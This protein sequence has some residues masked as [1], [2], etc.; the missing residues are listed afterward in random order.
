MALD[1]I[2]LHK[3]IPG[4]A[5]ILPCRIQKI[6][7]ISQTEVLFQVHGQGGRQQLLISC[8]S[9]YNRILLTKRN[10][11]TPSEPGN[12]IMV[13]RKYL[14]GATIHTVRQAGLDR[15]CEFLIR[16][17]N[18]LGDPEDLRLVTEL[19]G[20]YA[21]IILVSAA[22]NVID[23]LK[24]IPPFE[25]TRRTIHPGAQFQ[26]TPP[27]DKRNPF[28]DPYIEADKTLTQQFAGISPFLA[29]EIE[30]R[31]RA[32]QSFPDIMQEIEA[33]D[34][35][36]IANDQNEA[37]FHC[38][39]L[40]SVGP[41]RSYPVFEGFDILYYHKEE[42]ER[43][44]EISGDI[45]HTVKRELKHQTTKLPRLLKEYDD[46]C[47]NA[48]WQKY[49]DLLYIHNITD[50][51]GQ[52][53]IE[54]EDYETGS[55]IKVPLDPKLDGSRN[56]QKCYTKYTKLKK[57]QQYLQEQ[58]A[59]CE[60]EI[61]YFQGLLE[62]L[63]QADFK[64]AEEIKDEL[65][66]GGYMKD[67]KQK[68]FRK[69]KDTG[70]S[71]RTVRLEDGTEISFGRN[72]LQNE[73]LTWHHARRNEIWLHAKDYHGAHVVIHTPEPDENA[74]RTAAMIAAYYSAG[75]NS[76]SVPVNWCKVS[77]LKKIPGAK[78]GMVQLGSYKTIYI[79][80]EP[81]LP[82]WLGFSED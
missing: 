57:G 77:Q 65:V 14:E 43:I 44:K 7:Q 40:T 9:Q 12:F 39:E 16:R 60:N 26:E 30:F 10:Y 29:K 62:Q 34:R 41:C 31:M 20:K 4:I 64:V 52:T 6:Y 79:D 37:V 45:F 66:R 55:M 47:D 18:E 13:L 53:F 19:M 49:G 69:K 22:G 48:R 75:R 73:A 68:K 2:L 61:S 8:H 56:A 1:G 35:I 17:R 71:F 80:P 38:I 54:L 63:E 32:G 67:K 76:S 3:I 15:W 46:A 78:P 21:N 59:I 11:P 58:I 81:D 24:R 74:L 27:Q 50:T 5:D 28:T 70:P 42:K 82:E 33:S 25:N 72:N 51:K 36:Y 23:A